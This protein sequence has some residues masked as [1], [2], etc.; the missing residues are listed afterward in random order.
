MFV[1]T[2]KPTAK[3]V[4]EAENW[5]ADLIV[6]G[7][8]ARNVVGEILLGSVAQGVLY[9]APCPVMVLKPRE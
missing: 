3:I 9:K 1:E 8:H 2:G 6:M 4:E 7:P 5:P